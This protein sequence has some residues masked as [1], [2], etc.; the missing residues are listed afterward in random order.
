M[1]NDSSK[2][3]QFLEKYYQKEEI[4]IK[5]L[6][7]KLKEI[8]EYQ[9]FREYFL[10]QI[11]KEIENLLKEKFLEIEEQDILLEEPPAYVQGE[12]CFACFGLAK[13]LKKSPLLL[14]EELMDL[15]NN[16]QGKNYID[17]VK[18][19]GAY[20]NIFLK[21]EVYSKIL[22]Q[23]IFLGEKF[24]ESD[25]NKNQKV[26]I[27]Y[28]SPNIAKP[29]GLNHLPSTIIGQVLGNIYEQTGA[30]VI[31]HNYLG[32][33]GTNFGALLWAYLH[34]GDDEKIKKEPV[35]ELKNLYVRFFEEAS[36]NEKLIEEARELFNRLE[37]GDKEL[38]NLWK[39]FRDLSV[40]SFKKVYERLGINFDIYLGES[41]FLKEVESVINEAIEKGI[42]KQNGQ[43]VVVENLKNLPSFLLRKEDGATLYLSRDLAALKVRFEKFDLNLLL[44]VVGSEQSLH[45]EQLF[46]LAE[47]M[48]YL[49]NDKK[50]QHV[51]F[52]L[53]L[54]E[55]KKMA[56]RKGSLIEMEDL[57]NEAVERAE[58]IILKKNPKI[59]SQKAK[60]IAE[61]IGLGAVIYNSLRSS[62]LQNI[63]FNWERVLNF[64]AAS[65]PYLQY[66]CVRIKS[67]LRKA[68]PKKEA[69]IDHVLFEN[70]I[71][72]QIIK[73]LMFFPAVIL[74][75]Q[76]EN[77]P[78]FVC[79]YLEE[80][81][82]LFN[83]F[84]DEV[85]VL[86][87][88][89]ENL[90]LARINLIEAVLLVLEKGLKLLNIKIPEEM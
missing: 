42:A 34:W 65:A 14:A 25:I 2:L 39:K 56:T 9:D 43:L 3:F 46:A 17:Q 35:Q 40:K 13:K 37:Q 11:Q 36:Q 87:T 88:E 75:A 44:Y 55:G 30:K 59:S 82:Q 71:E 68:E 74:R 48:G 58:K 90:R 66:S 76:K 45:F 89:D 15:I 38:L 12:L 1:A 18:C 22:E 85:P 6:N 60:K 5:K 73:K 72:Y 24:G 16:S 64:E 52:G 32:D 28:S 26:L 31:R 41:Y 51:P 78:H 86:K 69:N 63:D 4:G 67:I 19:E 62:R 29:I 84:Y 8:R 57:L 77:S 23:I 21:K 61:M 83:K 33:W 7:E 53:I 47:A 10:F 20:I 54:I 70:P 27:D 81:A 80:L 49:N 79:G 50:A